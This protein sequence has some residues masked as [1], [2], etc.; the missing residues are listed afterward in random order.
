MQVVQVKAGATHVQKLSLKV[1]RSVVLGASPD[2][3]THS[4][5]CSCYL[6]TLQQ[7][8]SVHYEFKL[9]GYD[10]SF[11]ARFQAA[12]KEGADAKSQQP[13]EVIKSART[14]NADKVLQHGSFVAP[15]DGHLML[16][17]CASP[18]KLN[19]LTRGLV[20]GQLV[21]DFPWQGAACE[22]LCHRA[23]RLGLCLLASISLLVHA[24]SAKAGQNLPVGSAISTV[25]GPG[26]I[27]GRRWR[28]LHLDRKS[29]V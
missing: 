4:A 10:I 15:Q 27:E 22:S 24:C 18:L 13:V 7:D 2:T 6:P 17:W 11:S 8:D 16:I 5:C 25:Y 29:V 23:V 21:L 14:T 26:T 3:A 12:P 28:F 20:Q 1:R 9:A 19:L